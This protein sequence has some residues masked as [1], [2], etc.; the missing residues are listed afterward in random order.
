[1][2]KKLSTLLVPLL[3]ACGETPLGPTPQAG[4]LSVTVEVAVDTPGAPARWVEAQV[5]NGRGQGVPG[6]IVHFHSE[7]SSNIRLDVVPDS[8][9]TDASGIARIQVQ[10]NRYAGEAW[11]VA[12]AEADGVLRDSTLYRVVPGQPVGHVYTPEMYGWEGAPAPLQVLLRDRLHNEWPAE[13][14]RCE[15]DDARVV[16]Q[17]CTATAPFGR[18]AV[19]VESEWGVEQR[20]LNVLRPGLFAAR[21]PGSASTFEFDGT[22]RGVF[23]A[24]DHRPAWIPGTDSLVHARREDTGVRLHVAQYSG[25][26]VRPLT[27]VSDTADQHSSVSPDGEWIYFTR[28]PSPGGG[29]ELWRVRRD[30]SAAARLGPPAAPGYWAGQ[31]S[32]SPD[33]RR[34]AFVAQPTENAEGEVRILDVDSGVVHG[35]GVWGSNPRWRP[36]TEWIGYVAWVPEQYGAGELRLV[37]AQGRPGDVLHPTVTDYDWSPD[38]ALFV[39]S[40]NVCTSES[41]IN[42]FGRMWQQDVATGVHARM[43][44]IVYASGSNTLRYRVVTGLAWRR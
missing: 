44:F 19:R 7:G 3:T 39:A 8:A 30:G 28:T 9:A 23:N 21:R 17:G 34:L 6:V 35:T 14:V 13:S 1:M 32:V 11:I 38:G 26:G 33:G 36:G 12:R 25:S 10:A 37:D 40:A 41:Q 22:E 16:F 4:A 18:Y 5:L 27:A 43:P 42:C 24:W 29:S 20:V 15:S 2:R 31:P